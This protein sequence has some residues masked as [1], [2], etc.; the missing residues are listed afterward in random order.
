MKNNSWAREVKSPKGETSASQQLREDKFAALWK[1]R[2]SKPA[3]VTVGVHE[4]IDY[5]AMKVTATVYLNC[6][7][8]EEAINKASEMAFFKALEVVRDGWSE[9]KKG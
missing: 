7:Q 9:L 8:N 4:G 1:N 6:D 2:D 3:G 5:G